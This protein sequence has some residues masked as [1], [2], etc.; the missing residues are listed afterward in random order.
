MKNINAKDFDQKFDNGEDILDYCDIDNI[1]KLNQEQ[2]RVSIDIPIWIIQS[3]D[4][5][6]H[7]LGISRQAI[8]KLS[9]VDHIKQVRSEGFLINH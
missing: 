4:T 5:E 1:S 7:K 9:L 6:A 3:L 2:K 8:I